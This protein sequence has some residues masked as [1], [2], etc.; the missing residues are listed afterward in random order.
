MAKYRRY[1]GNLGK[2]I[3]F[4]ENWSGATKG[5]LLLFSRG[6][7]FRG[8]VPLTFD[9]SGC[10]KKLKKSHE[11]FKWQSHY[12]PKGASWLTGNNWVK[13]KAGRG[14]PEIVNLWERLRTI[15]VAE[16]KN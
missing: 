16:L 4:V 10:K 3:V 15:Q 14:H 13:I 9:R 8:Y 6:R 5:T 1:D 12:S 11:S 2:K 7:L